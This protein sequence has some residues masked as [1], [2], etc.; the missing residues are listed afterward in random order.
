MQDLQNS[1]YEFVCRKAKAAPRLTNSDIDKYYENR[2]VTNHELDILETS[3]NQV[4][5]AGR[6][7]TSILQK[8]Q[9]PTSI[10][11]AESSSSTCRV[12]EYPFIGE[13]GEVE[14]RA[15]PSYRALEGING[16]KKKRQ[17][18]RRRFITFVVFKIINAA[19]ATFAPMAYSIG[20][21]NIGQA[22]HKLQLYGVGLA[23]DE[24]VKA[25]MANF[26]CFLKNDLPQTYYPF[27]A[28]EG[29]D[30]F[31]HKALHAMISTVFSDFKKKWANKSAEGSKER[32]KEDDRE[33]LRPDLQITINNQIVLF[34]E[35]KP[36]SC[37]T[38]LK[39]LADR[40][41]LAN[42]A[43]DEL[44]AS[45]RKHIRLPFVTTIQVFGH[46]ME[47]HTVSLQNGLYHFH[48]Q[49]QMYVPRARDDAGPV[50]ACLQALYSVKSWLQ[51]LRLPPTF[52]LVQSRPRPAELDDIKKS[53]ITPTKRI[54]F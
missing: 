23:N 42:L 21:D 50:R 29:E 47:I 28:D 27:S 33:G 45:L 38:E 35:V 4:I 17:A 19:E 40:W 11:T 20:V 30:S 9:E 24:T 18:E 46:R 37:A 14:H 51:D 7:L 26:Q 43:K 16:H 2:I 5:A 10:P 39:Y 13:T 49:F 34:M 3:S 32:R 48:Q 36:P 15:S 1:S 31:V 41:K 8:R 12:S 6:K 22:F 53:K 44:D 54:M 25:T 52:E